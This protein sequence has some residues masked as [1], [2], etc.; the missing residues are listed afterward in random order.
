MPLRVPRHEGRGRAEHAVPERPGTCGKEA[1]E[2]LTP[3]GSLGPDSAAQHLALWGWMVAAQ[4]KRGALGLLQARVQ[5]GVLHCTE[6]P[7]LPGHAHCMARGPPGSVWPWEQSQAG[8]AALTPGGGG[9][10]PGNPK[11]VPP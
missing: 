5:E 6:G 9:H 1:A 3:T 2:S 8:A 11:S 7:G 10:H 4:G